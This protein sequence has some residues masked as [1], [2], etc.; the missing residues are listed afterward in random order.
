MSTLEKAIQNSRNSFTNGE[1]IQRLSSLIRIVTD[2]KEPVSATILREY[3]TKGLFKIFEELGIK[4]EIIDNPVNDKP[5]FLIGTRIESSEYKTILFYGHGDTVPLQ[6]GDWYEGIN[7]NE[8]KVIDDKIY[9]RGIA[10][11]KGQHF[12]NLMALLSVLKT[13]KKLGFNLKI[14]FEMG[15]EIGSPGL[16]ELCELYKEDLK[17]DVLIASDGPR[18]SVDVPTIF[19]GSRGAVN[20]ELEVKYRSGAHHS[21]NWGGVL[22]DPAIR[23]SHALSMITDKNGEILID[24]WKPNS[25]TSEVKSRLKDLPATISEK[26]DIDENWGEP[27]LTPNEKLFGWN[28]FS[29]LAIKS[30]DIDVPVNAIQP[31][32]KALCQLRFVVGTEPLKIISSLRK[33]LD[34][35]G[36]TDVEIIT[37]NAINFEASRTDLSSNW[38][39]KVEQILQNFYGDQIHVIPNLAGSLPNNCFTDILKIPTIW[40]PHSYKECSQ[41]APNEH[42]PIALLEQSLLLMT[43]LYWNLGE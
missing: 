43:D 13:K 10:D 22:R 15:E 41:H 38:L 29:I 42:L 32:A 26:L 36:F 28:S 39:K 25:L 12:I 33:H 20:F 31:S 4:S 11:N 16:F 27:G 40:I 19:L 35:F 2:S 7:P 24:Q 23:L 18:V 5:P 1:F 6:K 17:S 30:G 37:E 14:I 9:G 8:L 21:G 3:Y 34:E